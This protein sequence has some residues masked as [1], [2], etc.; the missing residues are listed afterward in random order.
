M[1]ITISLAD[2]DAYL[3]KLFKELWQRSEVECGICTD[4]I[5]ER[6]GVI[7]VTE[8]AKLNIEKMFHA[9]CLNRW[10]QE[11][12]RDPFNRN[13]KM[14]FNFPPRTLREARELLNCVNGFI[15]DQ[16]A[17]R[18]FAEEYDRAHSNSHID[19]ELDFASL[20]NY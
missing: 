9:H 13:V 10:R 7:A 18:L 3:F 15:G 20:L 14:W 1:L 5:G 6:E 11:H 19:M 16:D 2:K 17:D 4:R 12:R 8:Q